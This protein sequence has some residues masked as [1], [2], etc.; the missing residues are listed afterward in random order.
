MTHPSPHAAGCSHVT[1]AL[2]KKMQ[3]DVS[4]EAPGTQL[5][6][7]ATHTLPVS[8]SILECRGDGWSCDALFAPC[9]SFGTKGH[10]W[11]S[12]QDRRSSEGHEALRSAWGRAS[13][14]VLEGLP[15]GPLRKGSTC[16]V[17]L[18]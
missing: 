15:P 2:A 12:R 5:Q 10:A 3:T 9:G 8:F 1:K 16:G 4:K 7:A 11:W 13:M 6:C 17:Q 14:P 18:P